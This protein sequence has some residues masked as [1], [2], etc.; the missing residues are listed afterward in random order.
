MSESG[1][2]SQRVAFDFDEALALVRDRGKALVLMHDNP[3]PDCMAAAECMRLLL[4]AR[5]DLEVTVARGGIIGRPENRAMVQVLGLAHVPVDQVDFKAFDVIAMVDTQ[6]ET[7]NNSLP[8]GHK[9]D[10]VVDHHPLRGPAVRAPWC[11]I[12]DTYGASSS[13]TYDYLRRAGLS[14]DANLATAL[15][16]AIKSE[17]RDLG[18]E[19]SEHEM[20][21]YQELVPRA[22]MEKLHDIAEPKVPA[23]HFASLDRALRNAEVRGMLVTANLGD[24][25]YPDLVAEMADLL[26]PY[27]RAHWV[28]CMGQHAGNVYLSL[29]TDQEHAHAGGVI[30]RLVAGRGAA[31]G[32]GMIAGGRLHGK[33]KSEAEL[34]TIYGELANGLALELN[35]EKEIV[36]PLL[37]AR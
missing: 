32:H 5:A 1:G 31:G 30:R 8:V 29:R 19:S 2:G 4:T 33:V 7:G 28:M 6:P 3:D 10:I 9:I 36:V 24:L 25:D 17:T 13:I 12:R 16:Y 34:A 11:D 18:R 26:L 27:E 21:V 35:V 20:A 14:V 15:L 37:A 22:D 23:A